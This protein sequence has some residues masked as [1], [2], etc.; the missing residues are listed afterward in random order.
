MVYIMVMFPNM[1]QVLLSVAYVIFNSLLTTLCCEAEWQSFA[2]RANTLR[3]T[4]PD[5]E[6]RST[7]F[8]SLPLRWGLPFRFA[9]FIMLWTLSQGL[10]LVVVET[11]I[12]D[13][14]IDS[15]TSPEVTP[16]LE[17]SAPALNTSRFPFQF[18]PSS[19]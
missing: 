16:F 4:S 17:S 11:Y 1:W 18:F 13:V 9:F 7:Y 19:S 10:F 6:Q 15:A 12:S 2:T 14:Q 5:G 8:I 3:V